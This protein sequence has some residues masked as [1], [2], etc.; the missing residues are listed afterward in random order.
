MNRAL[1]VPP[2][3]PAGKQHHFFIC[4]HQGSG[5]DQAKILHLL[6][7]KIGCSVWHDNSE[8][9]EDRCLAGMKAG[10]SN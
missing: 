10:V 8:Q 4:H 3:L 5:G 1:L 6:L 2:P 7:E 9:T